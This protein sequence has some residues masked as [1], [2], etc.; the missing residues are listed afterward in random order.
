MSVLTRPHSLTGVVAKLTEDEK[1]DLIEA[2]LRWFEIINSI[3]T[4]ALERREDAG[5]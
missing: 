5:K 1:T 4:V 3:L 2:S